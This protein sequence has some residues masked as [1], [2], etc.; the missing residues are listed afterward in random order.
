ME[1]PV[2]AVCEHC[3][4]L[5]A[6]ARSLRMRGEETPERC[7]ACGREVMVHGR[8]RYPSAYVSRISRELHATPPLAT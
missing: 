3:V 8:E 5:R 1:V 4:F 2:Y 7:P 6:F